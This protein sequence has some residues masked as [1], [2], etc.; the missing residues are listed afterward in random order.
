MKFTRMIMEVEA[1]EEIGIENIKYMLTESSIP[2]IKPS[3]YNIEIPDFT[4]QFS[5][6]SDHTGKPQLRE[7]IAKD[8]PGLGKE[9]VLLTI[10]AALGLFIVN[11]YLLDKGDHLVVLHPN[12]ATNF[13]VPKSLGIDMSLHRLSFEEEWKLDLEK[14]ES[15][16]TPKTKLL[17]ITYPN[18]P[19]GVTIDEKTLKKVINIAE[20]HDI[21]LLVDETYRMLTYDKPLPTAASLSSKAISVESLSKTYGAPGIRVGWISTQDA[22]LLEGLL[23]TKE[24]IHINSPSYMEEIGHQILLKK[25]EILAKT[26]PEN[27]K[28]KDY[29]AKWIEETREI[30]WI[31]P[32][33][34]VVCFPR[35][36]PDVQVDI[37]KFYDVLNK[38]YK[39]YV[40]PGHWFGFSKRYF[41]VGYSHI[42][43][44]TLQNGLETVNQS[45]NEAIIE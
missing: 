2:D 7:Q 42:S 15:L 4:N 35:F 36:K 22:N 37:E 40:G 3:D 19:T 23:A 13:E 38:K 5:G 11:S 24:Q 14:F 39:T 34:G 29:M 1:P 20:S 16:I 26:Q 45:I 25:D 30:E 18:N 33:A 32:E 44:E 43:M 8:Y 41:R 6:Y 17:S 12:Y 10:G 9:N 31:E 21:P 27:R 28:K